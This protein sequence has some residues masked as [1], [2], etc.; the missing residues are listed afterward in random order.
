MINDPKINKLNSDK[1]KIT[2]FIILWYS[3]G[4]GTQKIV[5]LINILSYPLFLR[6][7][8][9]KVIKSGEFLIKEII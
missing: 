6:K 1:T 4:Y 8:V 7:Y 2:N 5:I 3:G 9:I